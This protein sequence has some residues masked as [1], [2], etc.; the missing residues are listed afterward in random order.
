MCGAAAV[1]HLPPGVVEY[2]TH[3]EGPDKEASRVWHAVDAPAASRGLVFCMQSDQLP[4][5]VIV[6]GSGQAEWSLMGWPA[7]LYP[8]QGGSGAA[9]P[10]RWSNVQ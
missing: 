9:V 6:A 10:G 7:A 2:G 8:L 5:P 1:L 4:K 3:M